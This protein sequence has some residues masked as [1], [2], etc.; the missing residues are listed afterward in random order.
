MTSLHFLIVEQL[1]IHPFSGVPKECLSTLSPLTFMV[2]LI[3]MKVFRLLCASRHSSREKI[4][5]FSYSSR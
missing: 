2:A 5:V 4:P 3:Y 1:D